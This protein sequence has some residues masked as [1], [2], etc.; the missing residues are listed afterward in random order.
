VHLTPV[1]SLEKYAL[2]STAR[3]ASLRIT[4]NTRE[5]GMPQIV[6]AATAGANAQNLRRGA[7]VK[8]EQFAKRARLY[9]LKWTSGRVSDF[10]SGKVAPTLPTLYLVTA[11]LTDLLGR[12]VAVEE[13]FAG[14]GRVALNDRVNLKL[15]TVRS[16]FREGFTVTISDMPDERDRHDK[17][18]AEYIERLERIPESL[19]AGMTIGEYRDVSGAMSDSDLRMCKN[20]G[21]DQTL[22]AAAMAKLWKQPFTAERDK[23]AEV[24]ANPQ[25]RGQISR[26]LKAELL[27]II[28]GQDTA[29]GDD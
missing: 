6:P 1:L 11:V 27:S 2:G 24:D 13:L 14:E 4:T 19:T 28:R 22:G 3:L 21:I 29:D 16:G 23:R 9:G 26:Q 25:R 8:L 7:D 5:A 20:L 18:M 12:E 15:D 10:E 17:S